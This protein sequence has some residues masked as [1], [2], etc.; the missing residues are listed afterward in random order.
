LTLAIEL[1]DFEQMKDQI[2]PCLSHANPSIKHG[3]LRFV[4]LLAQ[5]TD[6]KMLLAVIP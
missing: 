4:E 6:E 3:A 2:L 1:S 5:A